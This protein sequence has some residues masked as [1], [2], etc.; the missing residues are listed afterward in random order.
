[1]SGR[2]IAVVG[3]SGAGKDSVAAAMVAR[4]PALHWVRR[5]VTRPA[6]PGGE[7]F[8]PATEAEFARAEAGGAFA[9]AWR[10][11]GLAYGVPRAELACLGAGRDALVNLSRG[12]LGEAQARF[13]SLV[14]LHVTARPEL[15]AQRLAA[16]GRESMDDIA[17]RLVREAPLPEG[18][19][20]V[21]IDNSTTLAAAAGAALAALDSQEALP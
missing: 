18:L 14:V 9:L 10:A 15:R 3:P 13:P 8:V 12:V 20:V 16:R 7:P 4:R 1:M 11:H 19:R 5:V 2:L 17:A 21:R 6:E